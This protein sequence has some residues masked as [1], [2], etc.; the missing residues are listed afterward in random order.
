[1][2]RLGSA[3]RVGGVLAATALFIAGVRVNAHNRHDEG[4]FNLV[5]AT[6][7][8]I[9]EAF[10]DG[11]I[12]PEQLVRMYL[13]RIE[14]YDGKATATH[15][16]SYIAVNGDAVREAKHAKNCTGADIAIAT[17]RCRAFR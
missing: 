11:V 3:L 6:I 14:A 10:E 8:S 5:E 17:A 13:N 16:N 1:M 4:R 12:T 7:A 15:L 2:R 9:R